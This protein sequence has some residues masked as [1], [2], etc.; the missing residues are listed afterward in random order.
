MGL[1]RSSTG[2]SAK[3]EDI[4]L[5]TCKNQEVIALAGNPNVGKS[6]VFNLLTGLHQH[7]GNW[8]GKTVASAAGSFYH[9][10]KERTLIDIPGTYSL[11][12]NSP[13]E[14]VAGD[15][16]CF[17]NHRGVAVVCDAT[18]LERNLNLLLQIIETGKNVTVVVNLL[19]EARRKGIRIDL[20]LLSQRLGVTVIGSV[21]RR[22]REAERLKEALSKSLERPRRGIGCKYPDSI[23]KALEPILNTLDGKDV[24]GLDARWVA[25]RILEGDSRI[26][27]RI[28]RFLGRDIMGDE[29]IRKAL[30]DAL[31][32]LAINNIPAHKIGV[33][34]S[35]SIVAYCEKIASEVTTLTG[36]IS[37]SDLK[38]DRILTSRLL[39][40]PVMLGL[41]GVVFWITVSGA[42]YLSQGLAFLFGLIEKGLLW[43]LEAVNLPQEGI[44]FIIEGLFRVPS[45][46]VSVMLPPMAVFFPLF[47]LLEDAG[48]LPRIAFNL[49]RPF[50]KCGSCG[51]QALTMCMGLGCNAAGVVGC[52][53][54]G[55]ERERTAAVLTN[56]LIPCNGRFP[57]IITLIALFLGATPLSGLLKALLL[58]A[59]VLLGVA[60][61]FI[62]TKL[63]SLT[64]LKGA[65]SSYLLEL[66][67]YRRPDFGRIA[68]R[69]V[70]D[71][72]LF[73]LGRSVSVALP[74]GLVLWLLTNLKVG[75]S[76]LLTS[77]GRI[78]E[79]I[80][81]LLGL[82]GI[83][84][85]A[86]ILGF[87]ANEIVL[88]IAAMG[89]MGADHLCEL[90]AS[91]V[92]HI[93]I[94]NGWTPLTC[95][96]A[97]IFCLFHWPCSTTLLT[98]YKETKSLKWTLT[99]LLLPSSIG[100]LLCGAVAFIYRLIL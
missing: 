25:L 18:C 44:E 45:T 80:G 73:V 57:T 60:M 68:L 83:I 98:V 28:N 87:P 93:L 70:F 52:R 94:S 21:A 55:S 77:F 54:I 72:T 16:I 23:E 14:E 100:L 1:T 75:N 27:E 81:H 78:L 15:F 33:I 4:T 56:S 37:R 17:G 26:L 82:D 3:R 76:S 46:V 51:K 9:K 74:A 64:L 79:P 49:D 22:R 67:P 63:L 8:T 41:L 29:D 85:M 88:P 5:E 99:A 65:S 66:P 59:A 50:K 30:R 39:G 84:L 7:T 13:E 69:S 19:D 35:G 34:L 2:F 71:R 53:I 86:F 47:T 40:F 6:T 62:S 89:Y 48:Y 20:P 42:N 43:L 92:S 24:K 36:H 95:I 31:G 10:G 97:V 90:S 91:S 32:I 11:Y 96:C 58:T 61:T 38:A 12:P